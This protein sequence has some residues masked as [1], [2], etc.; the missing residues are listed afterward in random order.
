MGNQIIFS[1]NI[2]PANA[3]MEVSTDG[4]ASFAALP[5]TTVGSTQQGTL[6]G[7]TAGAYAAG[8]LI[9]RA[10]GYGSTTTQPSPSTVNVVATAYALPF[11]LLCDGDS[12][13]HGVYNDTP[14]PTLLATATGLAV[15]NQAVSGRTSQDMLTAAPTSV[16]PLRDTTKFAKEILT[17]IIGINDIRNGVPLA[18]LKAN[19]QTYIQGRVTA[20]FTVVAGTLMASIGD[21]DP[22]QLAMRQNYN[23][24]LQAN[25]ISWGAVAVCDLPSEP[26]LN[27]WPDQVIFQDG[28][29]PN[30][31][32]NNYE[33]R[34]VKV[35]VDAVL[36]SFGQTP[37]TYVFPINATTGEFYQSVGFENAALRDGVSATASGNTITYAQG[38]HMATTKAAGPNADPGRLRAKAT[39]GSTSEHYIL[40]VQAL[41]D[42]YSGNFPM[43]LEISGTAGVRA[44]GTST[45]QTNFYPLA[46]GD[47]VQMQIEQGS[48]FPGVVAQTR[49]A[50][51]INGTFIFTRVATMGTNDLQIVVV[52]LAASTA[53]NLQIQ[54]SSLYLLP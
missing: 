44:Y 54:S 13:T 4:G 53:T 2:T 16:D 14:Y 46:V 12:T 11:R 19:I 18:T 15:L 20:G 31:L 22:L 35:T 41:G 39:I 5:F 47:V 1:A 38:G 24:Y 26:R 45:G 33:A 7:V 23:A 49:M 34:R 48:P 30:T 27:N 52:G 3:P 21:N 50:L 6:T 43:S 9:M 29:H 17:V 37:S 40:G 32:G 51:Y 8:K 10:V 28:L 42:S 36:N 25:A